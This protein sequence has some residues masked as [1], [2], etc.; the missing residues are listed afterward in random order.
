[1]TDPDITDRL[2]K[3]PQDIRGIVE[4]RIQLWALEIGEKISSVSGKAIVTMVILF[5]VGLG[6]LFVMLALAMFL[7]EVLRNPAGGFLIVAVMLFVFAFFCWILLPRRIEQKVKLSILNA[8]LEQQ[9]K[10]KTIE[11][12]KSDE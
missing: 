8:L 3:L 11:E 7:G 1:M 6:I 5:I 10:P 12:S 9:P 4:T 2:K